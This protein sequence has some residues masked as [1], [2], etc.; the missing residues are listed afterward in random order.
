MCFFR[1]LFGFV[2]KFDNILLNMTKN[3]NNVCVH[4]VRD[5][6]VKCIVVTILCVNDRI[7]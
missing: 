1:L 4:L 6:Y 7:E 5:K 2:V 3:V